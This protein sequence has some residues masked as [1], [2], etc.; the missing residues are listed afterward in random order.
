MINNRP[1][2]EYQVNLGPPSVCWVNSPHAH[3]FSIFGP[4]RWKIHHHAL[5][6]S[7]SQRH[8]GSSLQL[9]SHISISSRSSFIEGSSL[10]ATVLSVP[11]QEIR[12]M[13]AS[14]FLNPHL[15]AFV[16]CSV[17]LHVGTHVDTLS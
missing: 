17:W 12:E 8:P 6:H 16:L 9:P 5:F 3:S 2:N 4:S 11:P 13:A 15:N 7:D 1:L 14:Y 10:C